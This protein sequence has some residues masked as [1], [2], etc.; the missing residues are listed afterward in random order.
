[1]KIKIYQINL[2]R[3]EKRLAFMHLEFARTITGNSG[4]DSSLYDKV[5]EGDVEC[6]NLEEVYTLF[7]L[8]HPAGFAGHSLSVSDV[9]ELYNRNGSEFWYLDEEGFVPVMME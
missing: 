5:Y 1:M 6:D 3:D 9:V 8:D 7:N 4:I 2:D